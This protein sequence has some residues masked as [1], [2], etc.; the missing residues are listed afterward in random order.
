MYD[1]LISLENLFGAWDEFKQGKQGKL[2]VQ[3]FERFLE[4]NIFTIHEELEKRRI[5][6]KLSKKYEDLQKE[7]IS[8][9]SFNQTLQSYLGVLKH[10]QGYGITR[11][12]EQMFDV[13]NE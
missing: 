10:C 13:R 5:L 3:V 9:E 1:K 6:K 12:I 2:D 7:L 11:K 8:A 4:D